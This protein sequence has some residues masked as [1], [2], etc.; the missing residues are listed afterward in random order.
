MKHLSAYL[1]LVL[2]GKETPS[3][4]DVTGLLKKLDIEAEAD[5]IELLVKSMEGKNIDEILEEGEKKL[6]SVGGSGGGGGAAAAAAPAAA[7][8]SA[9]PAAKEK[10]KPKEEA[11][12]VDVGGGDLFGGGAKGGY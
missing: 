10:E 7:A 5:Q 8:A 4:D 11:V 9:A 6:I 3:V 1:L 12:E 2:G